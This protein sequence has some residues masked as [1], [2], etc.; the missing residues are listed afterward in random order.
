MN[1]MTI[2]REHRLPSA[3]GVAMGVAFTAM[4][5]ALLRPKHDDEDL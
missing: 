3:E 1:G 4:A 2:T 5:V